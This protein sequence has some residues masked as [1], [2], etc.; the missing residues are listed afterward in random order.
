MRWHWLAALVWLIPHAVHA[1]SAD[2][3]VF[4]TSATRVQIDV[5]VQTR[6]G[7]VISGLSA[8]DFELVED[9]VPQRIENAELIGRGVAT[10]ATASEPHPAGVGPG[11]R[12]AGIVALVFGPVSHEGRAATYRAALKYLQSRAPGDYIGVF[13]VEPALTTFQFYTTDDASLLRAVEAAGVAPGRSFDRDNDRVLR[14]RADGNAGVP[15]TA[16]ADS[17]GRAPLAATPTPE[18]LISASY[19][20][21]SRLTAMAERMEQIFQALSRDHQGFGTTTGLLALLQAMAAVEG[22]KQV[23]F[24][25]EGI[26]IPPAVRQ[27]FSTVIATANR[28]GAAFYCVDAAGLRVHSDQ[29]SVGREI[30]ALSA[31]T[32]GT[33]TSSNPLNIG[34][35]YNRDDLMLDLL[36]K[37]PEAGLGMLSAAT[38]GRFVNNSNDLTKVF[39]LMDRDARSHYVLSYAPSNPR[40]RGEWRRVEIRVP[41]H[42]AEVRA[43]SGYVAPPDSVE[44]PARAHEWAAVAALTDSVRPG[45]IAF[46]QG[47]FLFPVPDTTRVVFAVDV[48]SRAVGVASSGA[49]A[50]QTDYTVFVRVQDVQKRT[51]KT[52]SQVVRTPRSATSAQPEPLF[53][54]TWSLAPGRYSVDV[55]VHDTVRQRAGT[56]HQELDIVV[57]AIVRL[58]SLMLVDPVTRSPAAGEGDAGPLQLGDLMMVPALTPVHQGGPG[59]TLA[60]F[61]EGVMTANSDPQADVEVVTGDRSVTKLA[62]KADKADASGRWS[63][64]GQLPLAAVPAG[65]YELRLSVAV[66][67]QRIERAAAFRIVE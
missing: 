59:R 21:N 47:V 9:G 65:E 27:Q 52:F 50:G 62:L 37:T 12:T 11:G 7:D 67:G 63:I 64:L 54:R 51:V 38:G 5:V 45:D 14:T 31:G 46:R 16:S 20:A 41:K 43:K 44:L 26:A 42:R 60:F 25:A 24:F 19:Q 58:G 18:A 53:L 34:G 56:S 32:V 55:A 23:V 3:G 2:L 15:V 17:P 66:E 4:R 30:E 39:R 40:F 36:Q 6:A 29:A 35:G 28:V 33:P 8:A 1:Q 48:D 13:A 10:S 49:N 61:A 22:R 57:D